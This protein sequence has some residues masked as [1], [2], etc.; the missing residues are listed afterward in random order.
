MK[1][2]FAILTVFVLAF[3][4]APAAGPSYDDASSVSGI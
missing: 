3:A 1:K 4:F 2:P